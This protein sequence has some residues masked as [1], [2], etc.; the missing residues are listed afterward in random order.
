MINRDELQEKWS[1]EYL[2]SNRKNILHITMRV[3]K[4]RIGIKILEKLEN[5]LNR[6]PKVLIS[7]PDKNIEESWKNDFKKWNYESIQELEE[8]F[9]KLDYYPKELMSGFK[10]SILVK[11]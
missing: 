4:C 2:D 1:N 9:D 6:K 11:P 10:K 5:Q 8:S 3:G 7:Y